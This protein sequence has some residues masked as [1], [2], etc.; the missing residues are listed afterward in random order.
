MRRVG[1]HMGGVLRAALVC[2]MGVQILLGMAWLI[3]N[4]GGLQNFQESSLLLAGESA[5]EGFYS[6]IL[7]RGLAAL[8]SSHLRILYGI[9]LAAAGIAAYGL[10][11]CFFDREK[12]GLRVLCTLA[13]IT[14][15]QVMQCHLA[16]LP[17]SLGTSLLLGETAL[18]IRAWKIGERGNSMERD[19]M[20]A[21]MLLGWL[22]I[23][24]VLPMYAWFVLPMLFVILWRTGKDRRGRARW[25][26]GL[27][28]LA[29]LLGSVTISCGW[30]PSHWNRRLAADALSRT[31][32]PYFQ[33]T[34]EVFP[35]PLHDEIGLVTAREVSAY[36]DGVER[37]L[38]PKLEEMHGAQE[39]T[40]LLWKLA[41]ICLQNNL[42]A[43]V[44]NIVWDMA[45]YHATPPI[46]AMQFKGR[47]YDAYS[48]INYE[49]MRSRTPVLT[50]YYVTYGSR[51]WWGM[52]MLA[53]GTWGCGRLCFP[54]CETSG[55]T[56]CSPKCKTSDGTSH[57]PK[58]KTSGGTS[59]SPR[60]ETSGGTSRFPGCKT[61]CADQ[62]KAQN[63][64][65]QGVSGEKAGERPGKR[66]LR[67]KIRT[68]LQCWLPVLA[69]VEWMIVSFVLSGSG[70]MD[71]K[72]T[73][74]VTVLW[75]VV[76]LQTLTGEE[77]SREWQS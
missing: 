56:S 67:G 42:K 54:G 21:A 18:W 31:G 32:W 66:L 74:W 47:A 7:Y 46:L 24:L 28:M 50:K 57:S 53:A 65:V 73:L 58:C 64:I 2:G 76:A 14:I 69:G 4:I 1:K 30:N 59:C 34:Y 71:Y 6:G 55:G 41:G 11:A 5:A 15:P 25:A 17:W 38:I 72:K 10:M 51:W 45:A 77:G 37:V 20:A 16:V 33:Y 22:L 27:T 40:A 61:P 9:Q 26:C 39:T 23:L 35:Q 60:C 68:L 70:V 12:T 29:L 8:L 62:K 44:K 49:Q 52:L 3:K 36:A 63:S 19:R 48:G 43:D 75:Y 13:L